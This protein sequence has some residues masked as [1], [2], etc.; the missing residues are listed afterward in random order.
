MCCFDFTKISNFHMSSS[1]KCCGS[2]VPQWK[3]TFRRP[4]T[5]LRTPGKLLHKICWTPQTCP[6]KVCPSSPR[7]PTLSFTVIPPLPFLSFPPLLFS[8]A[9]RSHPP[10]AGAGRPGPSQGKGE[11]LS[12]VKQTSLSVQCNLV[13]QVY[14][15]RLEI[16]SCCRLL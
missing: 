3:E 1:S 2:F 15:G 5:I 11:P 8:P 4:K 7:A 6:T 10:W 16:S 9:N 14:L 12:P 13:H